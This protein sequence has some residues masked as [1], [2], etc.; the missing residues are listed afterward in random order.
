MHSAVGPVRV[1]AAYTLTANPTCISSVLR[2]YMS[3]M[4]QEFS[5]GR[6]VPLEIFKVEPYI[7]QSFL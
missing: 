4:Y 7:Y 6:D 2:Y 3:P 1:A 5:F